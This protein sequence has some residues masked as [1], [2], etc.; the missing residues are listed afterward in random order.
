LIGIPTL[1]LKG[2]Y[3]AIATL[4]MAEIIRVILLN[5]EITNGAAGLWGIPKV[6]NW[7][8]LF[9]FAFATVVIIN[10][11]IRSSYGR[12]CISIR[13]DEIASESAG[14][15][16]T[17][18]KIAA[19]AIGAFF[20]GLAGGLNAAYF[21]VLEPKMFTFLKSVDMLIIVVTGGLG[22]ISGSVFVAIFLTILMEA[23]Q[24]VADFRM[25]VYGLILVILM[26]F[27]PQ[28]LMGTMEINDF[29]KRID[30]PFI[31]KEGF[32]RPGRKK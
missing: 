9:W 3:L 19:F 5:L 13:E 2:D 22:S 16:A 15:N 28:G 11:F 1:R 10:N 12:A 8:W 17:K 6:A 14:V 7:F 20:A 32:K 26:R 27:R 18:Y 21:P 4:G 24:A 30:L 31:N 25:I 29:M 23:L